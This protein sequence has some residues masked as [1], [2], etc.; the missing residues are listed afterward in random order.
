M[1]CIHEVS[2]EFLKGKRVF[3]RTDFNV[4]ISSGKV[5][6]T[7]RIDFCLK[8]ITYLKNSGARVIL[9]SHIGRQK[10]ETLAP[11]FKYL[12]TKLN[13]DF[14][15]E[16]N[17]VFISQKVEQMKEG[18]VVLL[19]NLRQQSGETDNSYAFAQFLASLGEIYVNDAFSASHREHTSIVT[20]PTLLKSYCG[21]QFKKELETLSKV[22]NPEH[23]FVVL[24]GGAKFETKIPVIESL[25]NVAD[26]VFVGGALA[27]D[28]LKANGYEVGQSKVSD[29]DKGYAENIFKNEKVILVDDV[30]VKSFLFNKNKSLK[31]IKNTDK[32]IDGGEKTANILAEKIKQAKLVVWN[33][34][35]GTF[36]QGDS[37]LSK[38]V[39]EAISKSNA[40]SIV[41][42]GDT[43]AEVKKLGKE[44]VFDFMSLSGGAMLEFIAKKTLPGIEVL[45]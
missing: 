21:C 6:E 2:P 44:N 19:E 7:A 39:I 28:I 34:P 11:V 26:S 8:T 4:P 27:N 13:L 22:F 16:W 10:N 42:G 23:P 32:I 5:A 15:P 9:I 12:K 24:M 33:G 25:L 35:F 37:F 3:V 18:D 17:E 40:Y 36:E 31:D 41:G 14:I 1:K 20:L 45:G 29:M 43:V 30:R 38:K